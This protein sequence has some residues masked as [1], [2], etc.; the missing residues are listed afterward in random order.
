MHTHVDQLQFGEL[1]VT[2]IDGTQYAL[3]D[4]QLIVKL[5]K[6]IV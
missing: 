5:R 6:E 4:Q 1:I 2:Q 3:I